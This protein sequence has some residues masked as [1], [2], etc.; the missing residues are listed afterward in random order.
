MFTLQRRPIL[1]VANR[2]SRS[3][4]AVNVRSLVVILAL[5]APLLVTQL[6]SAQDVPLPI[7]PGTLGREQGVPRSVEPGTLG[8]DQEPPKPK[9]IP[10]D[11]FP[12]PSAPKAP[13]ESKSYSFVLQSLT[14]E[15]STVFDRVD[16]LT[17][18]RPHLGKKIT[19]ATLFNIASGITRLYN[20]A[21]YALCVAYVPAQKIEE[22]GHAKIKV[23]E[24]FIDELVFT[25]ESHAL[26]K[27]AM[28]NLEKLKDEKPLTSKTLEALLLKVKDLPGLNIRTTVDKSDVNIG[29]AK[30]VVDVDYHSFSINAGL[31]NRGSDSQGPGRAELG[32]SLFGLLGRDSG[33]SLRGQSALDKNEFKY[34]GSNY[35]KVISDSGDKVGLIAYKSE[36]EPTLEALA[37]LRYIS[38]SEQVSVNYSRPLQRSRGKNI[39]AT[40]VLDV[41]ES[42]SE[43]AAGE[44]TGEKTRVLRLGLT[45]D[46]VSD[47]GATSL[48]GATLSQGLEILDATKNGAE[49]ISREDAEF[50]FT[51]LRIDGNHLQPLSRRFSLLFSLLA[52]YSPNSLS[53]S[54]ECGWGGEFMGRAYDDFELSGDACLLMSAELQ[55][56]LGGSPNGF[57]L[58]QPYVYWDGGELFDE[59]RNQRES[60]IGR[61]L[62]AGIRILIGQHHSINAEI[63]KPIADAVLQEESDDPRGFVSWRMNY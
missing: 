59:S 8:L 25:G 29:G 45:Y 41:R 5:A 22:R 18:S 62:G 7:D 27:R 28:R 20:E 36:S 9:S 52:Q 15:G 60:E 19:A 10:R 17:V 31:N 1:E 32:F 37:E 6:A 35:Q 40:A 39:E 46:W 14:V 34:L 50:D 63:A 24:G 16:L 30:L 48:L 56:N 12:D 55:L 38:S 61:S 54:E 26:S 11:L 2:K 49:N 57:R 53:S 4:L 43:V 42:T 58:I 44:I 47:G 33:F 3:T 23:V 13:A 51:S 21:G